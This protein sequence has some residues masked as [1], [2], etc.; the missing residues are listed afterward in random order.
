[1]QEL[2]SKVAVAAGISEEQ[3][4]K[5]IETV[6]E[7]LKQRVPESFRTQIDNLMSGGKLSD[8]VKQKL[9]ELSSEARGKAE[10]MIKEVRQKAEE[11]AGK[12]REIFS[13][14]KKQN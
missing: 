3:A 8:G 12:I 13:E 4:K 11:A 9:N 1:M 10:E 2:I 5:S 14:E 6:S 7:Y